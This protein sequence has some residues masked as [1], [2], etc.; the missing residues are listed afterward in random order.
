LLDNTYSGTH[1]RRRLLER[2]ILRNEDAVFSVANHVLCHPTIRR[3]ACHVFVLA[4][5]NVVCGVTSNTVVALMTEKQDTGALPNLPFARILGSG[6][7]CHDGSDGLMG[8][9]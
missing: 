8:R 2:N 5:S 6:A 4:K 1:E 3:Q 9:D 7:H